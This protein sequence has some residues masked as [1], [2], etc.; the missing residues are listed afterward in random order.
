MKQNLWFSLVVAIPLLTAATMT[1]G[2]EDDDGFISFFKR[3]PGVAP[4]TSE[5]YRE[6]CG[7]CHFAYQPGWLPEQS[8]RDMMSSLS[9][10]FGDNAELSQA[11]NRLILDYLVNNSAD[12]SDFRRSKK[13]MRSLGS[14]ASP[15]RI[16]E[17][18]YIKHEHDEIPNRLIA[19]NDKVGSLSQC[20]ACHQDADQGGFREGNIKIPGHGKWDD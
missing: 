15:Q 17:L 19:E 4:V 7:S 8:W 9:D 11:N 2:D 18:G 1:F 5:L 16:T 14:Y 3:Q 12:K 6:E 13:V 20:N 10:H